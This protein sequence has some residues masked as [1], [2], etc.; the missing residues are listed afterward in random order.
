MINPKLKP[1][2]KME[3]EKLNKAGII[4]LI[5]HSE[6]LSNLFIV[7]K[8]SGEIHVCVDFRDLKKSRIKYNYP[9]PNMEM[10]VSQVTGLT[11]MS[12]LDG[13]SS[14]NQVLVAEED[15]PKNTY[16]TPQEAYSYVCMPFGFNN[17]GETFQRA[18]DHAFKYLIGKFIIHYQDDLTIHSKLREECIKHLREVF[19][20]C[21]LYEIYLNPK[22]CLFVI[23]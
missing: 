17:P 4:F 19:E 22:K 2:V 23:L 16:I 13:F 18:M 20:C 1:L 8:K 9:V 7:K 11:L 14:Y 15:R 12:M 3:L 21:R 5:R 10:F 6:W